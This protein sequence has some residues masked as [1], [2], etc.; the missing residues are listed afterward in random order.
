MT[1]YVDVSAAVNARA[2]LGRY[3]ANVARAVADLKPE[4]VRVFYNSAGRAHVPWEIEHMP[5][6]SVRAGYKPWRMAVWMAQIVRLGFNRMVPDVACF[7]ATE[8]LLI[9]LRGVPTVLTVHDLVYRRFPEHH[10]RL[11]YL[12]LNATMPLFVRRAD[13]IIAISEHTKKDLVELYGTPPEKITVVY[14]AA[15]PHF[16]PPPENEKLNEALAHVRARYALP[17]QYLITLGT[18]EPRKNLPRLL[19]ALVGLR[20]DHPDLALV[21]AGVRGWL[22][23]E[24]FETIDNLNLT[25]HVRV[26]GYVPDDELSPLFWGAR[27][28]VVPSLYEGFGLPVL[29]AMASGCPVVSSDAASLPEVGG[30][31]ARYFDPTD[32][33]AMQ[34]AIDAVLRDEGLRSQMREAG[35]AQAGR[36]SWERAARETWAVYERVMA[37]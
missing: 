24:F 32:V 10:K 30:D 18:V 37:R 28:A 2:G 17:E 34:S 36:F 4:R 9:P 22:Y 6:R 25:Q 27:A 16:T 8:H 14:E 33:E 15:A 3:A 11:N 23:D 20:Q 7:H 12:Y 1:V 21:V 26:L 13:A 19:E 5:H 29:E 35:L 31:A